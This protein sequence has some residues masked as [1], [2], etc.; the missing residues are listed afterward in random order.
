MTHGM[1]D[2]IREVDVILLVGTRTNADGTD[3]WTSFP[4]DATFLPAWS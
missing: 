3:G 1:R 4:D 2:W